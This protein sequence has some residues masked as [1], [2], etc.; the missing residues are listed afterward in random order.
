MTSGLVPLAKMKIAPSAC[1]AA[2]SEYRSIRARHQPENVG[3]VS[4]MGDSRE[5]PDD[6]LHLDD[7]GTRCLT[8]QGSIRNVGELEQRLPWGP[9]DVALEHG[10]RLTRVL[11]IILLDA[12]APVDSER[13]VPER[14]KLERPCRIGEAIDRCAVRT[15]A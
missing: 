10:L 7:P 5:S 15:P 14:D 1:P 12:I 11:S 3:R 6:V 4:R 9:T 8:G 2:A 13:F